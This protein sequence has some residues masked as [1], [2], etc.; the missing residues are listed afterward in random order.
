MKQKLSKLGRNGGWS[1]WLKQQ[2]IPRST[3]DR[4]VLEHAE[5]FDLRDELPHR[6]PSEPLEGNICQAAYRT[7]DRFETMLRS[8]KSR[9]TFVKVAADLFGLEVDL[10]EVDSVRLTLPPPVEQANFDCRVP[11]V[12]RVM[13][14]GAVVPVDYELRDESMADFH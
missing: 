2:K 8:P 10:G 6:A 13:E 7:S 1:A 3:A 14:D 11:N 4:L 5:Y 12:I 9:M